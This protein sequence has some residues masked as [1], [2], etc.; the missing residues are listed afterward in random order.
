M[1]FL[2]YGVASSNGYDA[3]G[4]Y[5]RAQLLVNLCSTYNATA[6]DPSCTANFRAGR[7]ERTRGRGGE[8]RARP[9]PGPAPPAPAPAPAAAPV[10]VKDRRAGAR[11]SSWSTCWEARLMRRRSSASIA[12]NP[13]LI[14]AATILVI[15]VAV[16]LAYNANSGPAVRAGLLAQGP[17]PQ[18]RAARGGQRGPPGRRARRRGGLHPPAPACATGASWPSSG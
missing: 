5:L 17:G 2:Y 14:G 9:A 8:R 12:A 11:R 15:V 3:T 1:D 4:H 18:R 10:P 16:F 13:V 6:N 7:R